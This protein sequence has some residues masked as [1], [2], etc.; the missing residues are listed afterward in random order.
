[1]HC[2]DTKYVIHLSVLRSSACT[3]VFV[4]TKILTDKFG[5]FLVKLYSAATAETF[6]IFLEV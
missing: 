6:Y 1:M 2:R 3:A 4:S 5:T